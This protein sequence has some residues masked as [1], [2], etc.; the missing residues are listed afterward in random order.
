MF[1]LCK[2]KTSVNILRHNIITKNQSERLK[3][4][5]PSLPCP[6]TIFNMADAEEVE[7]VD[8]HMHLDINE[9]LSEAVRRCPILYD[10]TLKAFKDR[11]NI[12]CHSTQ[13]LWQG[14]TTGYWLFLL[15][16]ELLGVHKLYCFGDF[17]SAFYVKKQ[18][19]GKRHEEGLRHYVFFTGRTVTSLCRCSHLRYKHLMSYVVMLQVWTRLKRRVFVSIMERK[20]ELGLGLGLGLGGYELG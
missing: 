6:S 15:P 19:N 2:L 3:N 16:L 12:P 14:Y 10:K 8:E 4:I 7:C 9:L 11:N 1:R 13:A 18:H 17:F 20:L 5:E